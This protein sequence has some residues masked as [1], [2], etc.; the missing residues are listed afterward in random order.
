MTNESSPGTVTDA[1]ESELAE[2]SAHIES[3]TWRQLTLIRLIEPT[4]RWA[5]DGAT[6]YPA[7]LSWRIGL[8]SGAAREKIRIAHALGRLPLIDEAFANAKVSFSKVRA[9]TRVADSSN[10]QVLLEMALHTT[11]AHLERICRGSAPSSATRTG[12]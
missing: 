11:A 5:T 6:S 10:E 1:W 8:G 12:T 2:L 7:W 3:A 4:G 9:M